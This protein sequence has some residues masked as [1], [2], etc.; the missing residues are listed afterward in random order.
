M[1]RPLRQCLQSGLQSLGLTELSPEYF[2]AQ[3]PPLSV[4]ILL[5]VLFISIK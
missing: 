4:D 3:A 2:A 5:D 1:R